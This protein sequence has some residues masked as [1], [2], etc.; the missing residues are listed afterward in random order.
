MEK[1]VFTARLNAADWDSE[2]QAWRCPALEIPGATIQDIFISGERAD[3]RWYEILSG[4]AMIRWILPNPPPQIAAIISLGETLSL[5]SETDRWKKIGIVAPIVASLGAAIITGLVTYATKAP[6]PSVSHMLH[7]RID[8]IALGSTQRLPPPI[9]TINNTVQKPPLSFPVTAETTAIVDVS[10]AIDF[11][12]VVKKRDDDQREALSNVAAIAA[13]A[14]T[15]ISRLKQLNQLAL[16]TGCP[17]GA[18][19]VEIPHGRDI[20]G[21]SNEVINNINQLKS[22]SVSVLRPDDPAQPK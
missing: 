19:G 21:L 18:H 2:K 15:S 1:I 13:N 4:P 20:A 11:V 10:D 7:L 5:N 17:G 8:P 22:I 9:V 6:G 14:E 3:K 12:K 16:D